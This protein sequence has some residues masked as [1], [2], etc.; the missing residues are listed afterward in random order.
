MSKLSKVVGGAVRFTLG[1]NADYRLLRAMIRLHLA[2]RSH[3]A[4]AVSE[5]VRRDAPR[6]TAEMR[7]T[8]A[9]DIEVQAVFGYGESRDE[10]AW[11]RLREW[12]LDQDEVD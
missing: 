12:L 6:L 1:K 3:R 9:R 11:R 2:R 7:R 4:E 8:L 5:I 10:Q